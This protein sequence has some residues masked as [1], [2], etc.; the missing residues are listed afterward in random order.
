MEPILQLGAVCGVLGALWLGVLALKRRQGTLQQRGQLRVR[1]RVAISNNCQ[2]VVVDW[3]GREMLIATGAQ[4]C[5]LLTTRPA[6][7]PAPEGERV[8]AH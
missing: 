6:E 2:L 3:D 8:W 4:P 5:T 7:L 1:Q